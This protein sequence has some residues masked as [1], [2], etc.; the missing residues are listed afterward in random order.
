MD[1]KKRRP[2]S[3]STS[4]EGH[5]TAGRVLD[6]LEL[7]AYS[8]S[9][10]TLTDL[11][12]ELHAPRSSLFPLLKTLTQRGYLSLDEGG[13]YQLDTKIFELSMRTLGERDLR[14]VARPVLK[15]LSR[16]TGEGVLLAVLA[17]DKRAV[18]Y[19]DKVEGRHRLRYAVGLGE[20]RSLHATS[21]GKVF[22]AFMGLEERNDVVQ[23]IELERY[24]PKTITSKKTLLQEVAKVKSEGVCVNVDE[25]ELG[26]C[27]IAAPIFDHNG[28]LIAACALGA[29]KERVGKTLARLVPEVRTAAMTISK[30]LG[31]VPSAR[32]VKPKGKG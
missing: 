23:S 4:R 10:L 12:D 1:N 22:L 14:E 3:S 9:G 8:A 18:L 20:R 7:L 29:P 2:G 24:T 6:V 31:H 30:M 26:R 15:N 16:R 5:R 32:T 21:T 17:S 28:E 25:S 11:G 19:V 27:G 13:R